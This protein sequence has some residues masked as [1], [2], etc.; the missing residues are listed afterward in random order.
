MRPILKSISTILFASSLALIGLAF[1]ATETM[2]TAISPPVDCQKFR[3]DSIPPN[4]KWYCA[5]SCP[6]QGEYCTE[7]YDNLGNWTGC[8]CK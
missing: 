7:D 8:S 2:A 4:G 1:T 3:D 5:G 6:N